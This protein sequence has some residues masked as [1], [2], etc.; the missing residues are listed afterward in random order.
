MPPIIKTVSISKVYGEKPS[1]T[2]ALKEISIEIEEGEFVA[3]IGPSGSGKSTLMHILGCLDKPTSGEYYFKG[4]RVPKLSQN[5]LA[6]IRSK[7]IGFVFQTFNLLPRTS[8]IKNVQLPLIYAGFSQDKRF[9]RATELLTQMELTD[10]LQSTPAQLSGGQQQRVAIARALANNPSVI[11]ADEPT[12][13]LDTKSSRQ[14][15]NIFWN[16]NEQNHTIVI[17]THEP[18]IANFAKRIITI[19]DGLIENDKP[20]LSIVNKNLP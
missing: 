6:Q 18:E 12:G 14:I 16:L 1:Q 4:K 15:M 17:I 10:K 3:I 9:Q 8:V 11:F 13:N 20:N 2:V 19:R 7:E 5:K